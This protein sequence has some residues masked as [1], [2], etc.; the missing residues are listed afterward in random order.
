MPFWAVFACTRQHALLYG[1]RQLCGRVWRVSRLCHVSSLMGRD[2]TSTGRPGCGTR[3]RDGTKGD[4]RRVGFSVMP[5]VARFP[6]R[7]GNSR[8][9]RTFGPHRARCGPGGSLHQSASWRNGGAPKATRSA[10]SLGESGGPQVGTL[11]GTPFVHGVVNLSKMRTRLTVAAVYRE[12]PSCTR[13][14]R[15]LRFR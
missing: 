14:R 15:G 12:N 5:C 11:E 3:G 10:T 1:K 8:P 4:V 7:L 13:R 6:A 9:S 2:R